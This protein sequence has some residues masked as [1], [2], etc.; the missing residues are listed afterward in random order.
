M[1]KNDP[2]KLFSKTLT[3]TGMTASCLKAKM[4]SKTEVPSG[5]VGQMFFFFSAREATFYA[6][7]PDEQERSRQIICQN[8]N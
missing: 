4:G 6:H 7:L 2:G 5:H 8:V 3:K 1:A